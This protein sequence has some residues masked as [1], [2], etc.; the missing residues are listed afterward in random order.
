MVKQ[1]NTSMCILIFVTYSG[2]SLAQPCSDQLTL[3]P[4]QQSCLE[5][6]FLYELRLELKRVLKFYTMNG[7]PV[8]VH[9]VWVHTCACGVYTHALVRG[10]PMDSST[11]RVDP[12]LMV[13]GRVWRCLRGVTLAYSS[14]LAAIAQCSIGMPI[15]GLICCIFIYLFIREREKP[16]EAEGY[17]KWALSVFGG[18]T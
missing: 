9:H 16:M 4:K 18:S 2:P 3:W 8:N 14:S 7:S 5:S 17:F 15:P 6:L 1:W 11:S 12:F 13:L 10:K